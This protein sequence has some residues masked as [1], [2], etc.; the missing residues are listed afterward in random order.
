MQVLLSRNGETGGGRGGG[1]PQGA[2]HMA[3]FRLGCKRAMVGTRWVNSRP[4]CMSNLENA[5]LTF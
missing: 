4:G 3:A 2:V 5:T 1:Q